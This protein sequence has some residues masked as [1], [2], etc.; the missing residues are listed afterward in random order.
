M[1][2]PVLSTNEVFSTNLW[3]MES[4][5]G[6]VKDENVVKT[7]YDPCPV[8]FKVPPFNA[9]GGIHAPAYAVAIDGID[10]YSTPTATETNMFIPFAGFRG[11]DGF[12]WN[13]PRYAAIYW[14]ASPK[15][16]NIYE[17]NVFWHDIYSASI[18][19]SRTLAGGNSVYP[20]KDD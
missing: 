2:Y 1:T 9:F 20:I 17:G 5:V 19:Y 6:S 11:L 8:G 16:D 13:L 15:S 18:L 7:I 4:T 10:Y 12:A 14:T 3:S